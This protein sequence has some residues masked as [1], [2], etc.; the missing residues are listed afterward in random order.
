[1]L[2]VV[3]AV[4]GPQGNADLCER[5]SKDAYRFLIELFAV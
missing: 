4:F 3:V 2:D 5:G 1:L